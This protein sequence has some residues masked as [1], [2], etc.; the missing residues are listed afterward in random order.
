[1]G[2]K[3]ESMTRSTRTTCVTRCPVLA[4]AALL[5]C[6]AAPGRWARADVGPDAAEK[7]YERVS[8]S[9]V[10][11]RY[12]WEGEMGRREMAGTG[13]VVGKDGL[14][15]TS[16]SLFD[17]RT[18]RIPDEQLKE[19]KIL[20][21]SQDKDPEELDAEFLGRDDRTSMGFVKAKSPKKGDDA[22]DADSDKPAAKRE[23]KPL[24]FEEHAVRI[25]EPILSIGLLP[26]AAAY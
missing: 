9:L 22:A 6:L 1:M 10:V 14:V 24:K 12:T 11:V 4:A 25:G 13:I 7:L 8:P 23:W 16:G 15:M 3:G 2:D 5:V 20:I 19:F 17:I 18:Y 26:K 21:P